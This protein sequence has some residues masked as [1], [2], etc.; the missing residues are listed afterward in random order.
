MNAPTKL[1]IL[2]LITG[3]ALSGQVAP[4]RP[5]PRAA[6]RVLASDGHPMP[7]AVAPPVQVSND[8]NTYAAFPAGVELPDGSG[9][10]VSYSVG[11]THFQQTATRLRFSPDG[12]AW[13]EIVTPA[14][15][16]DATFNALAAE[17]MA[18]GGRIYGLQTKLA[19]T[20]TTVTAVT[21]YFRYSD[22]MGRTWSAR[23][24]LAGAGTKIGAAAGTWTFYGSS[25]AVLADGTIL[26]AGYGR[27]DGHAL[28]YRSGDR[29][30][31]WTP[32]GDIA[33]PAG[34]EFDEPQL[35][36]LADGRVAVT[37]RSD[38]TNAS[39]MYLAI[40]AADGA[41][42]LAPRVANY[43]ASGMPSCR[44]ITPGYIATVYRGW[45]DRADETYHPM[46]LG[47]MGVDAGTWG[48]GNVA[49]TPPAELGRFLYGV[50]LRLPDGGWLLVH[51]VEGPMGPMNPAASVWAERLT[52]RDV[53]SAPAPQA[54]H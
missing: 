48:R 22:D 53:P 28:I 30:A 7:V 34:R 8:F 33:P 51:A 25:L 20:G 27:A 1:A 19:V 43:D 26:R 5:A 12:Q 52:F 49:V 40:R 16:G 17:T 3:A 50:F 23:T 36:P 14:V 6:L 44:E 32:D 31:T 46:R 54:S 45:A 18:Q 29:G 35:C 39:R 37:L 24:A 41:S 9:V 4:A 13:S 47:I 21:P 42:Y 11:P 15:G 10:L 38:L 2:A